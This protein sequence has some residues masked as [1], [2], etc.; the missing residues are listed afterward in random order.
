[1]IGIVV[2]SHGELARDLVEAARRIVGELSGAAAVSIGWGEDPAAARQA[3]EAAL[4]EVGGDL[5][6]AALR[7]GQQQDAQDR[8]AVHGAAAARQR[9]ARAIAAGSVDESRRGPGVQP[10]P[11]TDLD[12]ALDHQDFFSSTSLAT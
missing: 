7:G 12:L 11:V 9:D 10:Q 3:I 4:A 5:E 6:Q 1:M 2:I 8:L